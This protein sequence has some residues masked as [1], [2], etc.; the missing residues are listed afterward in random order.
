MGLKL[1]KRGLICLYCCHNSVLYFWF[2]T[3]E[4][5]SLLWWNQ[6]RF[7][8][9][10]FYSI[11]IVGFRTVHISDRILSPHR[12]VFFNLIIASHHFSF[13]PSHLKSHTNWTYLHAKYYKKS[14][15]N[16]AAID[17]NWNLIICM[18]SFRG[19]CVG[20]GSVL[21]P[22]FNTFKFIQNFIFVEWHELSSI[23]Y[24]LSPL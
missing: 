17:M 6:F 11:S 2:V 24:C 1:C 8:F 18:Q 9:S 16:L 7:L 3:S 14:N 15:N 19:C 10:I 23:S 4:C 5:L 20:W 12:S 21:I 22:Y 13:I